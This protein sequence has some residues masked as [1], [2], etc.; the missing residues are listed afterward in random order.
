VKGILN[1][2]TFVQVILGL[3]PTIPEEQQH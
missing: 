1:Y 3:E 2:M